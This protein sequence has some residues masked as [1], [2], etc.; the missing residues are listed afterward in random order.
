[1]DP[2][3]D[4]LGERR[5][6]EGA[7]S[8]A[9]ER[10]CTW[11]SDDFCSDALT[12]FTL[13]ANETAWVVTRHPSGLASFEWGRNVSSGVHGQSGAS[14]RGEKAGRLATL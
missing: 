10:T 4:S 5:F 12:L 7:E 8:E 9:T 14:L 13:F 2:A 3:C 11:R 6:L 1:M